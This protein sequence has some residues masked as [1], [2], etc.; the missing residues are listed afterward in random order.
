M[1][2]TYVYD[3]YQIFSNNKIN[4]YWFSRSKNMQYKSYFEQT[5]L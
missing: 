5:K 4:E 2:Y 1:K 3:I